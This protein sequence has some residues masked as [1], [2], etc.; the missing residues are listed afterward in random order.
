M[1]KQIFAF[2]A[3][4]IIA[5]PFSG[6]ACDSKK[7]GTYLNISASTHSTAGNDLLVAKLRFEAEGDDAKALQN[8]VNKV[9]KLA[10]AKV[11]KLKD[12]DT[13][14]VSSVY[15]SSS[16]GKKDAPRKIIWHANQTMTI[17]G[18]AFEE[19]LTLTGKLQNMGL[20]LRSL[21][22]VTSLEKEEEI[23]DSLMEKAI[24]KLITKSKRVAVAMGKKDI[25][26]KS[27]NVDAPHF[28]MNPAYGQEV[29]LMGASSKNAPS[30]SPGT[31]RVTM[32]VRASVL[33]KD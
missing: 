29:S 16:R 19:I 15:K 30:A 32:T 26:I 18:K 17:K 10:L 2:I 31:N 27:I 1:K 4:L 25:E 11:K 28:P 22:Y 33:I 8:T 21:H 14:T 5:A 24:V 3:A 13:S 7:E 9:M 20:T 23:R 12:A 6:Y